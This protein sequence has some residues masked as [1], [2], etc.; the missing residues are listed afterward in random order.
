MVPSLT[1]AVGEIQKPVSNSPTS[2]ERIRMLSNRWGRM[3]EEKRARSVGVGEVEVCFCVENWDDLC[4]SINA[5]SL[6][7]IFDPN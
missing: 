2:S 1:W 4:V 3:E 6:P 5:I 7:P